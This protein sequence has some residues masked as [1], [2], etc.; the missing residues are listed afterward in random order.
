[1]D[2]LAAEHDEDEARG[3]PRR[4]AVRAITARDAAAWWIAGLRL[5]RRAPIRLALVCLLSLL[6]EGVLQLIPLAGVSISKV[7]VSLVSNGALVV[8]DRQWAT[9]R[10][11]WRGLLWSFEA[12]NRWPALQVAL[13]MAC[14]FVL[15][16]TLV[17]GLYGPGAFDA[18][19]LGHDPRQ[20]LGSRD[21]ILALILP[22]F[23]PY[24]LLMFT[25]PLVVLDRVRPIDAARASI[26][27]MISSPGALVVFC[28]SAV[29]L[30]T[31]TFFWG[32]GLLG[33]LVLPWMGLAAY[34]A[35]RNVFKDGC[36]SPA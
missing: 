36:A 7:V 25:A 30:M 13:I 17:M 26:R 32:Y 35:Y 28:G 15:Q 11:E 10:F 34:A 3:E 6:I 33:I 5:W 21:F 16:M 9:G 2:D 31:A 23:L 19:V 14:V 24:T 27:T 18:V 20:L 22:G 8:I 29:L 12:K 4:V 1:V